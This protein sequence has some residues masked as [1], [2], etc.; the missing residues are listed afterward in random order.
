MI[1][2]PFNDLISKNARIA[3]NI[4]AQRRLGIGGS[5]EILT[6][7]F[8]LGFPRGRY[9]AARLNPLRPEIVWARNGQSFGALVKKFF[10]DLNQNRRGR[11]IIRQEKKPL[12]GK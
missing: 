6:K 11:M 8:S 7:D 4:T 10:F 2:S 12:G 1:F 9:P 5:G 3:E